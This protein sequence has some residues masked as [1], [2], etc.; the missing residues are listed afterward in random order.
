[1]GQDGIHAS[2]REATEALQYRLEYGAGSTI[3]YEQE[4]DRTPRF[5]YP[6]KAVMSLLNNLSLGNRDRV[7]EEFQ[8]VLKEILSRRLS[9]NSIRLAFNH[10][11]VDILQRLL[12]AN[13]ELGDIFGGTRMFG[14]A[15]YTKETL[16]EIRAW[17]IGLLNTTADFVKAKE[18]EAKAAALAQHYQ[19]EILAFIHENL[20]NDISIK[21]ISAHVGLSYSYVRK[22]FKDEMGK[23]IMDYINDLRA[24]EAKRLLRTSKMNVSE[25]AASLGYNNVQRF[26]RNFRK[27]EGITPQEFRKASIL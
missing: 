13:V 8:L 22:L 27:Y 1:M 4:Q 19:R 25:I 14:D 12:D 10:L 17:F 15:V 21:M 20:T 6:G 9:Y 11:L 24:K 2:Y 7:A 23:N 5:F 16:E 3:F 26:L 18:G